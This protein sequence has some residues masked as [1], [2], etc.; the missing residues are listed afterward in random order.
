MKV[1]Q[2]IAET[3]T[4]NELGA[5][6]IKTAGNYVSKVFKGPKKTP[7]A[8]T[9][10]PAAT[11]AAATTTTKVGNYTVTVTKAAE[12]SLSKVQSTVLTALKAI[13]ATGIAFNYWLEFHANEA[14]YK[15]FQ[16]NPAAEGA[17]K[18]KTPEEAWTFYQE[19]QQEALGKMINRLIAIIAPGV[20]SKVLKTSGK[21]I[22]FILPVI[23]GPVTLL[24]KAVGV[25][26]GPVGTG[27]YLGLIAF[28]E[29]NPIGREFIANGF[30][31]A[32]SGFTGRAAQAIMDKM[33]ELLKSYDGFGKDAVNAV[34]KAVGGV[35][36]AS[37]GSATAP[38]EVAAS[39]AAA[40]A[41]DKIPRE[42]QVTKQGKSVRIGGVEVVDAQGKRIPGL[43][44]DQRLAQMSADTFNLRN[45]W[46]D[47]PPT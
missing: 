7:D 8:P 28:F 23:G 18:D 47:Y 39:K 25:L 4:L 22:S 17:F 14:A 33:A 31:L 19:L 32:I 6:T 36:A 10:A 29:L 34:G 20:V 40:A 26:K 42:L 45:P 35:S 30:A 5:S 44:G 2:I 24:G 41:N 12:A 21:I 15:A 38:P 13:G 37:K 1:Y 16:K 43:E 27:A 9:T 46:L 3:Q 11:P